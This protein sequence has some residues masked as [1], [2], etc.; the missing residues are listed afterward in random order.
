MLSILVHA[1]CRVCT[2]SVLFSKSGMEAL[3]SGC[4]SQVFSFQNVCIPSCSLQ[5][6]RSFEALAHPPKC[7]PHWQ[8][9]GH[10]MSPGKEPP[11]G[12]A[13]ALP[14]HLH[15]VGVSAHSG[16]PE[17]WT[18]VKIKPGGHCALTQAGKGDPG[19]QKGLPRGPT[20]QLRS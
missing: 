15:S 11:Y 13:L 4:S 3:A 8:P 7:V 6:C 14:S 17:I 2:D 9:E 18:R 1:F 5:S 19:L 10:G 12:G 20:A 16:N